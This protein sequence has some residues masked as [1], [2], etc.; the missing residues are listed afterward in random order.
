MKVE[1]NSCSYGKCPYN[2]NDGLCGK[3]S[4]SIRT[5]VKDGTAIPVCG[6]GYDLNYEDTEKR[7]GE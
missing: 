5:V 3:N 7:S 6:F 4:I 1:I 2:T